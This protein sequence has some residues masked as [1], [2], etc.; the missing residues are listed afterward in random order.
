MEEI[1]FSNFYCL[2]IINTLAGTFS[3][4]LSKQPSKNPILY[5]V[6]EWLL[7]RAARAIKNQEEVQN[8]VKG[9]RQSSQQVLKKI[10]DVPKSSSLLLW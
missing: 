8:K 10:E 1:F 4:P 9:E 2:L 5:R 3:L 7:V 6:K